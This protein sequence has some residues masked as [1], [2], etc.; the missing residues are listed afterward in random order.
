MIQH[1]TLKNL[2]K[3]IPTLPQNTTRHKQRP[4]SQI[5]LPS[6]INLPNPRNIR[7]NIRNNHISHTTRQKPT[8]NIHKIRISHISNNRPHILSLKRL[9]RPHIHTQNKTTFAYNHQRSLH[10][11]PRSSTQIHN[12]ITL[13]NQTKPLNS[14]K[15]LISS[16]RTNL[17]LLSPT[18]KI[19][20]LT[21]PHPTLRQ[22]YAS[23]DG[24]AG[25]PAKPEIQSVNVTQTIGETAPKAPH[26]ESLLHI[27]HGHSIIEPIDGG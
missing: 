20:L 24:P 16:P 14:L 4:P 13:P 8:N 2:T 19:I 10:P 6:L 11:T 27:K 17:L 18:I 15:Q 9:N 1:I 21:L 26:R 7:R 12:H 5:N 25:T 22:N 23:P 3:K